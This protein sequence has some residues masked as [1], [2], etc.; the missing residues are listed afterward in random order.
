VLSRD[1]IN[2]C[3]VGRCSRTRAISSDDSPDDTES[4]AF[5]QARHRVAEEN[6]VVER[7]LP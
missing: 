4:S 7:A 1:R 5:E 3:E 6:I 2:D